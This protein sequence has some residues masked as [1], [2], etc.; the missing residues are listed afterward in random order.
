MAEDFVLGDWTAV[1]GVGGVGAAMAEELSHADLPGA[2]ALA[3]DCDVDALK[4]APNCVRLKLKGSSPAERAFLSARKRISKALD[5]ARS[6]AVVC[7]MGGTF[8]TEVA[9]LVAK[10]ARARGLFTAFFALV[11]FEFEGSFRRKRALAAVRSLSKEL[12]L[13]AVADNEYSWAAIGSSRTVEEARRF[14]RRQGV[15]A[16]EALARTIHRRPEIGGEAREL[17]RCAQGLP[18]ALGAGKRSSV[19][20]ALVAAVQHSLLPTGRLVDSSRIL[21]V[22]CADELPATGELRRTAVLLK[23]RLGPG[24]EFLTRL[25]RGKVRGAVAAVFAVPDASGEVFLESPGD[26][27]D[28]DEP[29][30][31]RYGVELHGRTTRLRK[32]S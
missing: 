20:G 17:S 16:V 31:L 2:R 8:G 29:A 25:A 28:L 27:F 21:A 5:G 10:L 11:P 9:P 12:D 19:A 24:A 1:V 3:I 13:C 18:C 22:V 23:S 7:A 14:A 32:A 4:R 6:A 30:Y 15:L 26:A